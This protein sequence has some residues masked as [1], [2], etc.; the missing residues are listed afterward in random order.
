MNF[1][2]P[3]LQMIFSY[4]NLIIIALLYF[5][6]VFCEDYLRKVGVIQ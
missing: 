3:I 5:T 2:H 6:R 4:Q 1:K